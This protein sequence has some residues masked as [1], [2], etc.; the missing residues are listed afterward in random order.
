M[1]VVEAIC[2]LEQI[3]KCR[4][5]ALLEI[6]YQENCPQENY[7]PENCPRESFPLWKYPLWIFPLW[8]L[9]PV[10]ITRQKF[11]PGK[12][13]PYENYIPWNLLPTYKSYKWQKKQNYKIVYLKESCVAQHPYQNNQGPLDDLTENTGLRYFLYRMKKIQK[14][15][16][17]RKLPN[18][19]Y[20]LFTIYLSC[21]CVKM[22]LTPCYC[23]QLS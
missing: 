21:H 16:T 8:K 22:S 15:K 9:L 6:R 12:I 13:V 7:P 20:F 18:G 1:F 2:I 23:S 10:K 3:T 14:S 11:A 17:K 5:G 4:F 19:I